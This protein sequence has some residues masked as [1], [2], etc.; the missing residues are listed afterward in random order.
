MAILKPAK[1]LPVT[2]TLG[3]PEPVDANGLLYRFQATLQQDNPQL[4]SDISNGTF[5]TLEDM[6]V[7]DYVT[8]EGAGRVMK[9]VAINSQT[10][11]TASVVVEDEF[12]LNQ[13]QD[14]SQNAQAYITGNPGVVFEVVEGRPILYPYSD[15]SSE[16]VGF[17]ENYATEIIS[18]F[19]YQREHKLVTVT[20][21][22]V[23]QLTLEVGD[24][25]TY[26]A[27]A[28]KYKLFETTDSIVLGTVVEIENPTTDTFRFNPAG[29]RIDISLTGTGPY[30]YF[31]N[32][33]PGK[34]TEIP[35]ISSDRIIPVFFK[36][37]DSQAIYFDGGVAGSG[38]EDSV[39]S[40]GTL[41]VENGA[42]TF[43]TYKLYV[44]YNTTTDSTPTE[45]FLDGTSVRI[46]LPEDSTMMFEADI[47]GRDSTGTDHCSFRIQGLV[48]RTSGSTVLVNTVNEVVVAETDDTWS[49]TVEADDTNDTIAVKVIGADATTIRWTGFVKTVIVTH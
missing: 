25:I 7:G 31:D 26:D 44:L 14:S 47:I 37:S 48:D 27:V 13:Q 41:T 12:R 40:Q 29:E 5:Y 8:T 19:D 49:A 28:G 6:N 21:G 35:P 2:F 3:V 42:S 30:Y 38:L 18:R 43:A 15:S 4:H 1:L 33:N 9:I 23:D 24:L 32:S 36:L 22:G 11:S 39:F 20:Q 17:I 16:I 10:V 46:D 34:L 45:L